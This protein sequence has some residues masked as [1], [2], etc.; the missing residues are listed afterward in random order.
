MTENTRPVVAE[1]ASEHRTPERQ[2]SVTALALFIV[3]VAFAAVVIGIIVV[4]RGAASG[5][6]EAVG[7]GASEVSAPG[8]L[9]WASSLGAES[10]GTPAIAGDLVVVGADD[11]V[12]AAF[13]HSDGEK[14]WEFDTGGA[15]RSAALVGDDALFITSDSG[16]VFALDHDGTELW[17][18]ETGVGPVRKLWDDFG[19]RPVLV[20]D[21][22]VVGT[23][24]GRLL[25]LA[26]A[27]G[28]ERWEY[29]TGAPMRSDITTGDGRVYAID[30]DGVVHAVDS[31]SGAAVW[32]KPL[33]G[34]G[35]T[36]PGFSAGVLVVGSRA[37]HVLGLDAA[38]GDELWRSSYGASWVQSGATIVGDRVTIGSSD[39][40]EV[41]QL[42]LVT[43]E[44]VW[45]ATIGGWPWG[46]PAQADG[47]YYASNISTEAM[48]PW[49]A[50]LFALDG[51]DGSVLW[52]AATGP[53]VDWAIDGQAM[54]GISGSPVVTADHVIVAGL[55]GV[56]SAFTR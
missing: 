26:A 54:F 13:T 5:A 30:R 14:V 40:G 12:L 53:A 27:D 42:D 24:D 51:T 52:S 35:T 37:L 18:V 31:A 9:A 8:T 38:T 50:S 25:A 36:S 32:A 56:L 39:I 21:S 20:G 44:A 48:K 33:G 29:T 41:R 43:G 23:A 15:L 7:A 4:V 11:G 1:P 2:H 16:A 45:V 17:R 47:V 34:A 49:D 46:I 3:V 10:W 19:S 6:E 22:V 28:A 55:D